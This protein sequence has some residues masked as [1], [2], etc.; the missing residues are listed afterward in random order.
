MSRPSSTALLLL[1]VAGW[2][3]A[4]GAAAVAAT[5]LL[6]FVAGFFPSF[7]ARLGLPGGDW[8]PSPSVLAYALI[9]TGVALATLLGA[10]L[11]QCRG[12]GALTSGGPLRPAAIL[13]L[14][15]LLFGWAIGV[16]VLSTAFP[17]FGAFAQGAVPAMLKGDDAPGPAMLIFGSL[18][19]M[20]LAP[21]AEETFFRGWL[22]DALNRRGHGVWVTAGVTGGLWLALHAVE[23]PARVLF[24]VPA[25]IAFSVARHRAG[26][27]RAALSLHLANNAMAVAMMALA[28][29]A[30]AG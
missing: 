26:G 7:L 27:L 16:T 5:V 9:A 15:L 6:A 23:A 2:I 21:L 18:L 28:R 4:A 8:F 30:P 29:L 3:A 24:L 14:C 13:R 20:V 12:G 1:G 22:W 25:A 19:I 11:W 10:A 17:A